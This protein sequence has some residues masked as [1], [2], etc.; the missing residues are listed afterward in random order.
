MAKKCVRASSMIIILTRRHRKRALADGSLAPPN[1]QVWSPL[2]VRAQDLHPL[3]VSC[4]LSGLV[5][6]L[7]GDGQEKIDDLS[8]ACLLSW[9]AWTLQQWADTVALDPRET[10]AQALISLQSPGCSGSART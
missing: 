9:I 7:A 4:L 10:I 5:S 6:A 3:F 2:L 8:A 1:V